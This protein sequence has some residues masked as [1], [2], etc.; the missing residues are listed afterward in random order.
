MHGP[1]C[2]SS[3]QLTKLPQQPLFLLS[4]FPHGWPGVMGNGDIPLNPLWPGLIFFSSCWV[5][6]SQES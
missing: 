4:V 3:E 6:G 2:V 1:P 5:S